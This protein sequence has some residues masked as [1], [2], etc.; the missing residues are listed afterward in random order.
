[1]SQQRGLTEHQKKTVRTMYAQDKKPSYIA[2]KMNLPINKVTNYLQYYKKNGSKVV[3]KKKAKTTLTAGNVQEIANTGLFLDTK[4]IKM[5]RKVIIID[6]KASSIE[7]SNGA[8]F[9]SIK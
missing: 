9:S 8:I 4:S 1:M 5:L 3:T 6:G 7:L 2:E